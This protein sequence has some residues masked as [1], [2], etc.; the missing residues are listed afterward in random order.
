M[1]ITDAILT[2]PRRIEPISGQNFSYVKLDDVLAILEQ[3]TPAALAVEQGPVATVVW[4]DP[5]TDMLLYERPHKIIDASVDFIEAAPIGTKLYAAPVAAPVQVHPENL[6]ERLEEQAEICQLAPLKS[7]LLETAAALHEAN[8]A[9]DDADKSRRTSD[10]ERDEA[11]NALS[12]VQA[13]VPVAVPSRDDV[14]REAL[15]HAREKMWE[16]G[17]S[18]DDLQPIRDALRLISGDTSK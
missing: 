1:K 12:H 3:G 6:I 15:E 4:Y 9:I 2:L 5:R 7:L 13:P 18:E 10:R 11:V 14:V 16:Y 8:L 17:F